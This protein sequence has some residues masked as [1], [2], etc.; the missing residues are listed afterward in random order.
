MIPFPPVD[1]YVNDSNFGA[2]IY[3]YIYYIPLLCAVRSTVSQRKKIVE[4]DL[5]SE[6]PIKKI[7]VSTEITGCFEEYP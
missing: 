6:Y 4:K 3:I 7:Q 2:R 5:E 1:V